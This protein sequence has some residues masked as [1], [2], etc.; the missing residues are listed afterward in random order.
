[1]LV[2]ISIASLF[3]IFDLIVMP[4]FS[5]TLGVNQWLSPKSKIRKKTQQKSV[6]LDINTAMSTISTK[7]NTKA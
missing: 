4:L 3:N 2:T 1:M 7:V 5:R 6:N